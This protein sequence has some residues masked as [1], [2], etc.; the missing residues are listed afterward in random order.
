MKN[1]SVIIEKVAEVYDWIDRKS[2]PQNQSCRACGKCCDF[3]SYDHRLFVTTPELMYLTIMLGTENIKTMTTS[4]CP[5]NL[6]GK[7]AVYDHRF[8]A[9]RIFF[10]KG[11]APL[12]SDLSEQV[13]RRLKSLCTEL[14]IPY[15]YAD[16]GTA[17]KNG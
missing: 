11:N 14:E 8:A 4:S 1:E 12:Q 9:C 16:L 7:C 17:L 15:N 2:R 10:C 13:S 6:A 5:Y 3:Q